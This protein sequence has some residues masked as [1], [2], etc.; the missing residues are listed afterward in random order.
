MVAQ[1]IDHFENLPVGVQA[2]GVFANREEREQAAEAARAAKKDEPPSVLPPRVRSARYLTDLQGVYTLTFQ[3]S[4][5]IVLLDCMNS[6]M[7]GRDRVI[8][9]TRIHKVLNQCAELFARMTAC[10]QRAL[11]MASPDAKFWEI[12]DDE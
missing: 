11:Y 1:P 4:A 6:V 10:W 7:R 12:V 8:E 3:R 5:A 9:L 2:P